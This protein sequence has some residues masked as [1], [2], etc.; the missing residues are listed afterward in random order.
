MLVPFITFFPMISLA[1][2][3]S[4]VSLTVPFVP[5]VIKFEKRGLAYAYLGLVFISAILIIFGIIEI[6]LFY[7][8][9][10]NYIF[11]G[12]GILGITVDISM[13]WGFS[14]RFKTNLA[15]KNINWR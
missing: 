15:K 10:T 9:N 5:D 7:D 6:K 1:L 11:I 8:I 3:M 13:C 12:A 2:V 4:S 14:D